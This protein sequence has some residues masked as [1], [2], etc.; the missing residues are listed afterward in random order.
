MGSRGQAHERKR[1]DDGTHGRV[2]RRM[3]A[4]HA[5]Q[6]RQRSGAVS[7]GACGRERERVCVCGTACGDGWRDDKSMVA[8]GCEA[9]GDLRMPVARHSACH[10]RQREPARQQAVRAS[11][12]PGWAVSPRSHTVA[13]APRLPWGTSGTHL[14]RGEGGRRE[15]IGRDETRRQRDAHRKGSMRHCPPPRPRG[16]L[17][18]TSPCASQRP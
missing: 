8:E 11:P 17:G 4:L 12:L 1:D 14:W 13:A 2:R 9:A 7:C 3:G 10:A 6:P 16:V 18:H 5:S 15:R